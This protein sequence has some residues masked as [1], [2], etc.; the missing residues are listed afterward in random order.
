MARQTCFPATRFLHQARDSAQPDVATRRTAMAL[1]LCALGFGAA[2]ALL[3]LRPKGQTPI[4][5]MG[6]DRIEDYRRSLAASPS[7]PQAAEHRM[8]LAQ[9]E[10]IQA[11]GHL[12]PVFEH[13]TA[14]FPEPGGSAGGYLWPHA[15]M[16]FDS[17][18]PG[19]FRM[20][21]TAIEVDLSQQPLRLFARQG[22][23]V[24]LPVRKDQDPPTFTV[25]K[26]AAI[27]LIQADSFEA[28][29]DQL[30]RF[31]GGLHFCF[32]STSPGRCTGGYEFF[33]DAAGLHEY[34]LTR[35][36]AGKATPLCEMSSGHHQPSEAITLDPA[37]GKRR[38]PST[39]VAAHNGYIAVRFNGRPLCQVKEPA[40]QG[41]YF[42][43]WGAPGIHQLSLELNA[44][45]QPFFVEASSLLDIQVTGEPLQEKEGDAYL[46]HNAFARDYNAFL[47][48]RSGETTPIEFENDYFLQFFGKAEADEAF[49]AIEGS[50]DIDAY[51]AF[52]AK[53]PIS[54]HSRQV[55]QRLYELAKEAGTP[56]AY[57]QYLAQ[58]PDT[59]RRL[60]V[61]RHLADAQWAAAV[62][63][64]TKA[65]LKRYLKKHPEGYHRARAQ[66]LLEATAYRKAHKAQVDKARRVRQQ[67]QEL[68]RTSPET[69]PWN[70]AIIDYVEGTIYFN[71][72]E[73]PT[74]SGSGTHAQAITM[75][76]AQVQAHETTCELLRRR[77]PEVETCLHAWNNE[78]GNV[79][80]SI[81]LALA[82]RDTIEQLYLPALQRQLEIDR[83]RLLE[84]LAELEQARPAGDY[85]DAYED[86]SLLSL[87]YEALGLRPQAVSAFYNYARSEKPS[88]VTWA[89]KQLAKKAPA[90]LQD[91]HMQWTVARFG[92]P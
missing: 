72:N 73:G 78:R 14:F 17:D 45:S 46:E 31:G 32:F 27:P 66:L 24:E 75:A 65:A 22:V 25:D 13:A 38:D 6:L 28:Q 16:I 11:R 47:A 15:R 48:A 50:T 20:R 64:P 79:G 84:L 5:A 68:V 40:F 89:A 35:H 7:G 83:G 23:P 51:V 61:R 74:L 10:T 90:L 91:P 62:P 41:G 49:A 21:A 36:A 55:E 58:Y 76:R 9:L 56:E 33:Y 53:H 8:R 34:A 19:L 2:C 54:A 77:L 42:L 18:E 52:L 39:Q 86:A 60:E 1:A 12:R 44:G 59:D 67:A 88:N 87:T 29:I 3:G 37:T 81:P 30:A 63:R 26:P 70:V 80:Q 92:E 82:L 57:Q 4:P 85:P 43:L 69:L 71:L